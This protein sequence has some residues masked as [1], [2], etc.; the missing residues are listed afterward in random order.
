MTTRLKAAVIGTGH[1]GRHHARNL[2]RIDGVDVTHIC[3]P[4]P[5][6]GK[7]AAQ[8]A[9][10]VWVPTLDELPDLDLVSIAAPTPLHHD[11]AGHFVDRGVHC[12]VEKPFCASLEEARD[13]AARV[14]SAGVV[15][16]V[17][18]IERFNPVLD[19]V[20]LASSPRHI[21]ARRLAPY[22]GR[23]VDTSV[24]F[25]LMIHDLDLV[26]GWA[27][28]DVVDL[29]AT[30][31]V[32]RGPE[33]DWASC[34]LRFASGSTAQVVASRVAPAPMRRT[35]LYLEDR[36][37]DIDFQARTA[38]VVDDSLEVKS[39]QGDET[40]PLYRELAHFVDRVRDRQ[41]PRV[42]HRE[43]LAAVELAERVLGAIPGR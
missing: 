15:V 26:L 23:S 7:Q 40:E 37:V 16:Q 22:P 14:E 29:A 10:A 33:V 25:D 19:H 31:G 20:D 32:V 3:D 34:R 30:G 6:R 18:H 8:A 4:D 36:T 41:P 17:G 24:V 35:T 42:S 38:D 12:L 11:I 13:L 39:A 27:D 28:S 21:D 43:G 5:G 9:S 1:L 2:A